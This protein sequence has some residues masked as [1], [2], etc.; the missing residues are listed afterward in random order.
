QRDDR[1]LGRA[2]ADVEHH[3]AARLVHGHAGTD[4]GRH[5]L[6]DEIDLARARAFGR[7]TDRAPLDLRRAVRHTDE[8]ARARAKKTRAVG[9]ADEVLEHALRDVE[10]GDDAVLQRADRGDVTRRTAKHVLG[11]DADG[12]EHLTAA[13]RLLANRDD[14]GLV[15][16][17]AAPTNV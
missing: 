13:A 6:F 11:F 9:L 12:L 1:D 10:V 4:R 7:L 2:A 14:R 15:Q 17:D 5:R 16:D 3:R 8:H